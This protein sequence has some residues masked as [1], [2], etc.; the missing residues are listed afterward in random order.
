MTEYELKKQELIRKGVFER[1]KQLKKDQWSE[2][3]EPTED[4]KYYGV[5]DEGMKLLNALE[6]S[7]KRK[8]ADFRQHAKFMSDFYDNLGLLTLGYSDLTRDSSSLDSKRH[9]VTQI[10]RTCFDDFI[11]KF[12]IS[13]NGKLHIHL[14]VAWN[15]KA[16]T[17]IRY[18]QDE[19]GE[20][21]T[22]T[23]VKKFDLQDL[24]Y[25]ETD[26]N[27]QPTKY[28]IYDL[29]LIDK[30]KHSTDKTANYTL[31]ALNTMESYITKDEQ[32]DIENLID[33]ELVLQVNHS[34]IITARN[35]PY[36]AWKKARNEQDRYI[37]KSARVF[38]TS[39]YDAHKF[40][41]K[42]VF[43]EWAE[44]NKYTNISAHPG[45]HIDLFGDEFKLISIDDY[46]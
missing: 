46:K 6:L 21:H 18:T 9:T 16:D 40:D 41:R 19:K 27:G 39:F 32:I 3:F 4:P 20:K 5:D 11:G 7:T 44:E 22:N 12:E 43:R 24:W 37:K 2:G 17:F 34:N 45:E 15:G 28:G 30:N 25:G 14:L 33:E 42:S 29:I 8:K 13:P 35:T 1:F 23:L 38:E 26:K 31:K 10:L 36:Q